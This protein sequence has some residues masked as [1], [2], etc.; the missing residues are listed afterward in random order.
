MTNEIYL[1]NAA[2]TKAYEEVA[3]VIADS[4]TNNYY[5]PSAFYLPS[6]EVEKDLSKA[7]KK[8]AQ[9]VGFLPEELFFTSGATESNNTIIKGV[10]DKARGNFNIITTSIEHPS[11]MNIFKN[12]EEKGVE[13][14]YIP[15]NSKGK[16]DYNWLENNIDKNTILVSVMG[17]NNEIGSINDLVRVREIIDNHNPKA[18]FHTD[19]TQ[20]YLKTDDDRLNLKKAKPDALS[21]SAHKVHGPKGVG[22]LAIRKGT[23]VSPLLLGGGQEHHFRAGTENIPGILG[24]Y[25]AVEKL[26]KNKNEVNDNLKILKDYFLDNIKDIPDLIINSP[27]D[28]LPGLLSVS[29]PGIKAEVLLHMLEAKNIFIA[30]GS[31][32]STHEKDSYVHKALDF[33][34]LRSEGTIRVSLSE[35]NTKEDIDTTTKEVKKGVES[36]RKLTRFNK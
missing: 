13:V 35:F 5:N 8:L 21:V 15:V 18:V 9:S 16:L 6:I 26:D 3:A 12:L 33:D 17:A 32:C 36:L 22:M 28:G 14:R 27:E 20:A 23:K 1:D 30:S 7:R 19:F 24:F 31:A 25:T 4:L 2:T 34:K 11:V 10:V 29:F